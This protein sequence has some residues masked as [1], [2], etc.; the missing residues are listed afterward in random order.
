MRSGKTEKEMLTQRREE[1]FQAINAAQIYD[2]FL[3][4]R[5]R[6]KCI[7]FNPYHNLITTGAIIS[8]L[9][10]RKLGLQAFK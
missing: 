9:E 7:L 3:R 5:P 2:F 6:A 8:I 10:L 4:V 1:E